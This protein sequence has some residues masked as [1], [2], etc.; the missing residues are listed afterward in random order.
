VPA[1]NDLVE[2]LRPYRKTGLSLAAVII[3]LTVIFRINVIWA[4]EWQVFSGQVPGA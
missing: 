2:L 1:K 4:R 3:P